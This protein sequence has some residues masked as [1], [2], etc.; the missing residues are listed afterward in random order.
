MAKQ[1]REPRK[2]ESYRGARRNRARREKLIWRELPR[3]MGDRGGQIIRNMGSVFVN[4]PN[5]RYAQIRVMLPE[6]DLKG[7]PTYA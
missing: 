7:R 4:D 5:I 3:R 1:K 6:S 2:A